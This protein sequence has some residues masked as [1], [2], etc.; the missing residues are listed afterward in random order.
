VR[1]RNEG[2]IGTRRGDLSEASN[3]PSIYPSLPDPFLSSQILG[4]EGSRHGPQDRGQ[5]KTKADPT[6]LDQKGG[7]EGE[8]SGGDAGVGIEGEARLVLR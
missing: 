8:R 2:V 3:V 5:A 6:M 7:R 1:G 4:Q